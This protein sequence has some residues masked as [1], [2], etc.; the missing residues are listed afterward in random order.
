[1][2]KIV[3]ASF[4]ALL[5]SA[6]LAAPAAAQAPAYV[7]KWGNNPLQCLVDQS[8][9]AAP[10]LLDRRGFAQHKTRCAFNSVRKIGKAS[11]RMRSNCT[12][13]GD[14]QRHSFTVAVNG[15]AMN[16]RDRAGA[17]NLVRCP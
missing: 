10:M 13:E 9:P 4:A 7:G 6:A 11:W 3:L 2:R 8:L 1:M 16:M 12:V 15:N 17:R 14:R 5:A